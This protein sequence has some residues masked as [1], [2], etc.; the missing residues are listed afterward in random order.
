VAFGQKCKPYV[1]RQSSPIGYRLSGAR[2]GGQCGMA[3]PEPRSNAAPWR[4]PAPCG[5]CW[6]PVDRAVGLRDG[7]TAK[8]VQRAVEGPLRCK[9]RK[10]RRARRARR[11]AL[12]MGSEAADRRSPSAGS[13]RRRQKAIP[14]GI[15]RQ[16]PRVGHAADAGSQGTR[17]R[18]GSGATWMGRVSPARCG[19]CPACSALDRSGCRA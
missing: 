5:H 13:V 6:R 16:L 11:Q 18:T 9:V 10:S 17:L 15:V 7:A 12:R 4:T 14:L 19:P 1:H 3:C 8:S 2:R